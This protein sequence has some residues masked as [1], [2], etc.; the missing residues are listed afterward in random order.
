MNG[1][2]DAAIPELGLV[3]K[4][5]HR[6]RGIGRKLLRAVIQTAQVEGIP[7]LSLSVSPR[8]LARALYESEGFRKVG[9]SGTSW[10]LMLRFERA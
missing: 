1:F 4:G 6:S 8:N 10:T 2:V 5:G 3:V 9:E 7:G